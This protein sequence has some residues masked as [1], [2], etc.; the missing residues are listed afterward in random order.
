MEIKVLWRDHDSKI[1]SHTGGFIVQGPS[2]VQSSFSLHRALVGTGLLD[3]AEVLAYHMGC[4][5]HCGVFGKFPDNT[6]DIIVPKVGRFQDG[7]GDIGARVSIACEG[8]EK[9]LLG[10]QAP[11]IAKHRQTQTYQI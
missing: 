1:G 11:C 10:R 4:A 8:T 5:T 2:E 9:Y 7:D 6:D 3:R